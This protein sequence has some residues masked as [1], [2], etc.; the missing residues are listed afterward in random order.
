MFILTK[1]LQLFK[2]ELKVWNKSTFGNV[3]TNVKS[4]EDLLGKIQFQIQN[5]GYSGY[6]KKQEI[7]VQNSLFD[8][9]RHGRVLLEGEI[10][11]QMVAGG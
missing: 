3:S 9:F 11:G 2:K 5:E 10:Q 6:L 4:A 7:N 1:K 8:G